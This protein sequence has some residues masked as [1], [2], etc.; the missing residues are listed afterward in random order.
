MVTIACHSPL[1]YYFPFDGNAVDH[2][3]N[4]HDG[5]VH[6]ATLVAD[7]Q[8][9]AQGAYSF[10]G[11]GWIEA[12]GDALPIGDSDRTLTMWLNPSAENALSGIVDWGQQNCTG[13]MWGFGYVDPPRSGEAATTT[14]PALT[15]P[16]G[17]LELRGPPVHRPQ[18]PPLSGQRSDGRY[19]LDD[20][21]MTM[22]SALWIGAQTTTN[23]AA[24]IT[25]YYFGALDSVRVYNRALTDAELDMV[26]NLLP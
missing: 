24:D 15:L 23:Q 12:A 6:G 13:N 4:G 25:D 7:R 2:S 8:G 5:M 1:A 21:P 18:S 11:T 10:D 14:R 9:N 26:Q 16:S 17:Y 3:G 19:D 20:N 22:A